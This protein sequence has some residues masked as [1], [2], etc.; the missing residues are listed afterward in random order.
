MRSHDYCI[1]LEPVDYGSKI[2][3]NLIVTKRSAAKNYPARL[4]ITSPELELRIHLPAHKATLEYVNSQGSYTFGQIV[5]TIDKNARYL[6]VGYLTTAPDIVHKSGIGRMIL[7]KSAKHMI[8]NGF[9]K[10]HCSVIGAKYS[11]LE[12]YYSE[13]RKLAVKEGRQFAAEKKSIYKHFTRQNKPKKS[14]ISEKIRRRL[15]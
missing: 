6:S 10:Y 1:K 3:F 5:Y 7:L 15:K 13:V 2:I 9:G 11:N 14:A 4:L 8:L 12:E